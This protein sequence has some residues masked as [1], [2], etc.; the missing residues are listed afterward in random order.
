MSFLRKKD[1]CLITVYILIL[2]FQLFSEEIIKGEV[3]SII[4]NKVKHIA[5]SKLSIIFDDTCF[6]TYSNKEGLFYLKI[7]N[8]IHYPFNVFINCRGYCKR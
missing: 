5:F 6:E 1:F 4:N 3:N 7:D 2:P 8:E